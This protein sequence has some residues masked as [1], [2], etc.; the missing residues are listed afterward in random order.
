M[1]NRQAPRWFPRSFYSRVPIRDEED[2]HADGKDEEHDGSTTLSRHAASHAAGLRAAALLIIGTLCALIIVYALRLSKPDGH[3]P[4]ETSPASDHKHPRPHGNEAHERPHVRPP[5]KAQCGSSPAEARERDCIFE[6]QLGA[7]VPAACAW[8]EVR[9]EFL[10]VVGDMHTEWQWFWDKE[11]TREVVAEE[12]PQLQ[13][14]NYSAAYTTYPQAH[15]LH[16]LYCWRKVE[17]AI[18]H[19]IGLVDARSHQ[20]WHSKHCV[21]LLA[22][23]LTGQ[24]EEHAGLSYPIMYHDCVGLT[25][26]NES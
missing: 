17:Y 23:T 26:V 22:D 7:W 5:H 8:P 16:C 3:P 25:S 6:Q 12:I 21:T 13:S 18:E 20:F 10:D 9:D 15:S 4:T 1:E 14:G 19:G 11:L 2:E 24:G